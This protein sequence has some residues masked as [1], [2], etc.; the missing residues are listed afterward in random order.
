[1]LLIG[2]DCSLDCCCWA[3]APVA[4]PRRRAAPAQSVRV[5]FDRKARATMV[6]IPLICSV[7]LMSPFIQAR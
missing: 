3:A 7:L 1:V 5:E 6:K 2:C 4:N